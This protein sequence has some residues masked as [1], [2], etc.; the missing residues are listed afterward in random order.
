MG[1]DRNGGDW[2][3]G[4]AR[5]ALAKVLRQ[6]VVA[7]S[8]T[9]VAAVSCGGLDGPASSAGAPAQ[10]ATT[11]SKASAVLVPVIADNRD[12]R[13]AA[14]PDTTAAVNVR[15]RRFADL[16]ELYR[17]AIAEM[18]GQ[19]IRNDAGEIIGAQGVSVASGDIYYRDEDTGESFKGGD[20]A[21]AF[22]GGAAGT[23][24]V[25]G[26]ALRI[27][28]P[29][30]SRDGLAVVTAALTSDSSGC[31]GDDCITGH[32][33]KNNYI[34][35]Q[36]VGSETQ[37][38]SGGYGTA[39]YACCSSGTPVTYQG[40]LQCRVVTEWEPADPENG[41]YRPIP[42]AY[43][44]RPTQTCSYTTTVNSLT[45]GVTA[46]AP[47]GFAGNST[48]RSEANSRDVTLSN[49]AVGVGVSFLGIDDVAGVCGFHSGSRGGTTRTRAGNATDAQCG[50][51]TVFLTS[52]ASATS[53]EAATLQ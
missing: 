23:I 38:S 11:D 34:L 37:Q 1:N 53:T 30:P 19:P 18:G 49:W 7:G 17:F 44:Y 27:K 5:A 47:S 43:G 24:E 25:A 14:A 39:S 46:I 40:R 31:V 3:F 21:Q 15:S 16:A 51:N 50:G 8:I 28:E 12:L 22:L 6:G 36:S 4:S 45:L 48:V 32:S 42:V 52:T 35:Y 10:G 20:L 29:A 26:E 13:V 9:C 2:L 33:W 41:I